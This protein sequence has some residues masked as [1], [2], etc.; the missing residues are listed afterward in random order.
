MRTRP[1]IRK[2]VKWSGAIAC[3]T[4]LA[5]W[6]G[7]AW[8]A[9]G[10]SGVISV[11]SSSGEIHVALLPGKDASTYSGSY[12]R[13]QRC[14]LFESWFWWP[15]L[16]ADFKPGWSAARAKFWALLAPA[17][18]ATVAAWRLDARVRRRSRAGHCGSCG[19]DRTGVPAGA[20]C[21]E[22]GQGAATGA[23]A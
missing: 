14:R 8:S 20:V 3:V 21:P 1:A 15:P 9:V 2:T 11:E 18:L 4:L 5:A 6:I 17:A 22:C 13:R 12:Y 10:W 16:G 7:S 23:R 19:Y